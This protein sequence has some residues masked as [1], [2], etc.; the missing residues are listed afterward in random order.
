[1]NA[2]ST[3]TSFRVM[4]HAGYG[5]F[6]GTTHYY[7]DSAF[8]VGRI[9]RDADQSLCGASSGLVYPAPE[10]QTEAECRKCREIAGRYKRLQQTIEKINA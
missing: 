6:S 5:H 4:L 3:S 7:T 1:M 9:R 2:D 10:R 8:A